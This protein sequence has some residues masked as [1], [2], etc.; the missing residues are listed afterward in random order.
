M[1]EVPK[2]RWSDIGG[3]QEEV[4]QQLQEA[5][6]WP[7]KH[8]TAFTRIGA[9]PPRGPELFSKWVG[10]SEKAV[11]ALFARARAAA[12]SIVFF[13]EIDGLAVARDTG[14]GDGLSV[15]DRVMSQLL[16]EM[17]G[18]KSTKGVAVIAATNRPDI[19]DPALL[20]P[21]RFDR[22]LYV[23]PPNET[24]RQQIFQI[25]LHNTPCAP[26][27]DYGALAARTPS[28]T[29]ADITGVC[30]EAALATLEVILSPPL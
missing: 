14:H 21:G 3:G 13:D 30:R 24:A 5:V 20:R 2:V 1:L 19:I 22:L 26:D 9:Q 23:G 15:G 25:Q 4:K 7:Q 8:S 16:T 18:L 6:E 29:G 17:D 28:Y 12:P 27:V 10:E 11:Q